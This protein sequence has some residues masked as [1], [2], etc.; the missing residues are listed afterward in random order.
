MQSTLRKP[1]AAAA[2]LL[3][4]AALLAQPALAREHIVVPAPAAARAVVAVNDHDAHERNDW[5]DH[6]W[7]GHSNWRNDNLPP[8]IGE[9]TPLPGARTGDA[10]RTTVSAHFTDKA[11]G[12]D[13][14]SVRLRI[15]GRDVTAFSRIDG[16]DVR[17][18]NDLR[19]GRHVAE[20]TVRDRAGNAAR[21]SWQFDVVDHDHGSGRY[22]EAEGHWQ[23]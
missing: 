21:R 11:S 10:H 14:A 18:H 1:L 23:R 15:D 8:L 13:P 22:G 19:P 4:S 7:S 12:V 3:S 9:L 20:V 16:D 17:F 6:G 2:L 5:N